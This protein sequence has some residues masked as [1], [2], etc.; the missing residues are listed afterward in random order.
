MSAS[1][2]NKSSLSMAFPQAEGTFQIYISQLIHLS[3]GKWI[4][5]DKFIISLDCINIVQFLTTQLSSRCLATQGCHYIFNDSLQH[6]KK[7]T[8]TEEIKMCLCL[9][10]SRCRF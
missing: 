5:I 1:V 9:L 2:A 10:S 8:C 3:N 7:E 6:I 4:L